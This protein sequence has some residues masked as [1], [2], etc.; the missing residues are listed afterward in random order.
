MA[1]SKRLRLASI[2]FEAGF[3]VLGV[4]LALVAN[5]WRSDVKARQ[6]AEVARAGIIE[7]IRTNRAA[8]EEMRD[9]HRVLIDSLRTRPPDG[10]PPFHLYQRG[11]ANAATTLSTAWDAA[12]ATDAVSFMD[13]DD[14]LA[15]SALY[16]QQDRYERTTLEIGAVIFG[17][18]FE[19]GSAGVARNVRSL[20]DINGS[21]YY[22]ELGLL[23][24]YDR[25]LEQ[26][27][28]L[29]PASTGS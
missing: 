14:V 22:Q 2:L 15:F 17:E 21:L 6:H 25:T 3:V 16:A 18:L 1:D 8:V 11:F 27:T 19:T 4:F 10:P 23:A 20:A 9:Y 13:F 5:E 28:G 7:E 24:A 29:A 12:N 26:V